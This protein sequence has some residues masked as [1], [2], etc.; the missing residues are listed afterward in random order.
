K[1]KRSDKILI[2][3]YNSDDIGTKTSNFYLPL[4]VGFDLHLTRRCMFNV[5]Y[6]FSYAYSDY[7][8]GYNFQQPTANNKY[9]DMFS[10]LSFGLN[11]YIGTVTKGKRAIG[12]GRQRHNPNKNYPYQR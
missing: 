7:L 1:F 3:D 4:C 10:V 11:W 2:T 5:N 6:E 9:N 8:D 12:Y